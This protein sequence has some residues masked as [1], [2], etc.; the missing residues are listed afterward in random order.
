M[1]SVQAKIDVRI[2]EFMKDDECIG[3]IKQLNLA[4]YNQL[5]PELEEID[6]PMNT[7]ANKVNVN[8]EANNANN[9]IE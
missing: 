7:E 6:K 5:P 9:K 4:L 2:Q 1:K 8:T 3:N